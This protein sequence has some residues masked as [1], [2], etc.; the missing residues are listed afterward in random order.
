MMSVSIGKIQG[1]KLL[2]SDKRH[3]I[4]IGFDPLMADSKQELKPEN[5]NQ[6][7]FTYRG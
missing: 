5:G 7:I 3:F 1:E 6:E 2:N 4:S